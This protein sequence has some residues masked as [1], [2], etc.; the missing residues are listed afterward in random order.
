METP[1]SIVSDEEEDESP[2]AGTPTIP[3][4]LRHQSPHSSSESSRVTIFSVHVFPKVCPRVV[5]TTHFS[6][7]VILT[8]QSSEPESTDRRG[9]TETSDYMIRSVWE[10]NRSK[11]G[12]HSLL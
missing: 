3:L 9:R 10:E 5:V 6:V 4:C 11:K 1:E 12:K 2:V 7:G 8:P